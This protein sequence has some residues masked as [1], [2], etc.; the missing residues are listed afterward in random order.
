MP[1]LVF[2][3]IPHTH[4]DREWYLARGQFGAR[5]VRMVDE[6]VDL[7]KREPR[8]PGFLLDGQTIL[9]EDYLR[10]RPDQ[11]PVIRELV[12]NG[13]L[14]TG[15]WYVLADE[16]I[17]SGESLIRNLLLGRADADRWGRR[18]D[19]LYSPDAFGH[20]P[21]MPALAREFG[22]P[23]GVAWRGVDP[24]VPS[25]LLLWNGA[26][27]AAL[28]L[29]HL[30]PDGYE[31][32]SGLPAHPE[33]LSQQWPG[34]RDVLVSRARSR[35]VAVFVGAD[36]HHARRDLVELR[37]QL[38]ELEPGNEVRLSRLQD[39]M[40]A[41]R[42]APGLPAIEG[43]QR[44]YGYTWTLQDVHS[45][46]APLKRRNSR[47]ELWLTRFAEPLAA[48]AARS[49]GRD[50][51]PLL[52]HAWRTLVQCH[53]HD[54]LCGSVSDPVARDVETRFDV[55]EGTVREMVR[56]TLDHLVGHD[57]D[58]ARDR[59]EQR[60]PAMVLWNPAVRRRGGLVFAE[61]TWFRRDVVVGPP[62][63]RKPNH[64]R[65][66]QPFSLAIA[67]ES[68]P[69]QVLEIVPAEERLDARHHYPDQD[70]VDL[71]RIAF[72]APETAGLGTA[73][74]QLIERKGP[75]GRRGVYAWGTRLGNDFLELEVER[76]GSLSVRDLRTGQEFTGLLALEDQ[77]DRGDCYTFCPAGRVTRAD[78]P[79]DTRI[80]AQ[81]PLVAA[82]E[83]S[84]PGV[85]LLLVLA[86][87]DPVLRCTLEIDNHATNHRLRARL[88]TGVPGAVALAG[89]QFGTI[90][91]APVPNP[92]GHYPGETP[93]RT[94]PAHRFVAVQ[95]A[96]GLALLCP[97]FFEYELDADGDLLLT[98]LRSV[99]ALSRN[100]LTTRPG[101]AGWPVATPLAQCLGV[102]RIDFA[103]APL[104]RN[105]DPASLYRMWEDCFLPLRAT[106]YRDWL[107][108]PATP[109]PTLE[110]TGPG[111]VL[112]TIKPAEQG[113]GVV[114]RCFNVSGREVQAVLR[115]SWRVGRAYRV[116]ADETRME[117]LA[118]VD[119]GR[120]ISFSVSAGGVVTVLLEP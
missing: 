77:P 26:D 97:G 47:L 84:R 115:P 58:V 56:G 101:H 95:D 33:L 34:V 60:R 21:I 6:L 118:P 36:H 29:Y 27:G 11:E 45:T 65:G 74:L 48:L 116:R 38:A 79:I 3:L 91:R 114:V 78:D 69:V 19:V 61:T 15:P 54:A 88:P 57:P 35:H 43:E 46:R 66:F 64:G 5:L 96:R 119:Q 68:I 90:E 80:L 13:S 30:P 12:G 2:H 111:L 17:P 41:V 24:E 108:H 55:V 7:L 10:V 85:R 81:G 112:S 39:F 62:G 28:V 75:E 8:I 92:E 83:V 63:N 106:W 93:A 49:G 86:A 59:A 120:A 44:R 53:F 42:E 72:Q 113:D 16:Q 4:W 105:D 76:D 20:P 103:I 1:S 89:A 32:G 100:D 104:T 22:I 110:L 67:G 107:P 71:V 14:E 23:T 40:A 50:Q 87:G 109:G 25:D 37:R 70:E 82:L 51:R 99:G 117:N 94:A 73:T 102:H 52:T 9:L 18:L 31:I 98:L